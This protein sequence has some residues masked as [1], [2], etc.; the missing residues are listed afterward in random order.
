[1]YSFSE[2]LKESEKLAGEMNH[3]FVTVDHLMLVALKVPS[4]REMFDD[5]DIGSEYL[6]KNITG[7]LQTANIPS[8]TGGTGLVATTPMVAKIFEELKKSSIKEQLKLKDNTIEPYFIVYE[9]MSFMGTAFAACLDELDIQVRELSIQIQ[10]YIS[11][12]VI[13]LDPEKRSQIIN[14]GMEQRPKP[15]VEDFTDDL[16]AQ[17]AAKAFGKMIGRENELHGLTQILSRMKK[18][19]PLLVGEAGTGKTEIVNGLATL[20]VEGKVPDT[21]KDVT[22]LSLN[23]SA[24]TAGTKYRGDFEERV[25]T[26]LK[27]LDERPNVILFIDE[28]HM[29][30]GAGTSTT[31]SMDLGNMLKPA[32]SSGNIRII[33]STTLDEYRKTIEKD[34]ALSR[35]FMKIDINEPTVDETRK[36]VQGVKSMYE[37]YHNVKYSAGALKAVVDLSGKFLQTKKYPD[38]AI[39]LLDAAGA[40]NSV[41]ENPLDTITEQEIAREVAYSANLPVE[42]VTCTESSR[43]RDLESNI[44][45]RV[46]GQDSAVSQLTS[47]VMVARAGLREHASIQGAFLMVGSSG[48]GK[49]EVA[50]SLAESMGVELVRFDMSEFA[51]SHTVS[52]LLGAP[53]GYTGHD[54]GNGMLLDKIEQFPNCVLLLDEIEK[55]NPNVLLPLLQ[56]MDEGHLTG[57][58]GKIVHFNNVTL[59]MTT[60]LGTKNAN[61]RGIGLNSKNDDGITKAIKEFLPPEFINRIDSIIRFN[62]LSTEVLGE[63]LNKYMKELNDSLK[64]HKVKVQLDAKAKS[65]I[66][67][68]GTTPGMGA[69]PMKRCIATNIKEVLA[70]KLLFGELSEGVN[71]TVKFTVEDDK[72]VL[73]SIK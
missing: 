25:D 9:C 64:Q 29:M 17:A 44:R 47:N 61:S 71:K 57:S 65:W 20:I 15:K 2:F 38:K 40:R 28:I 8:S 37:K 14:M 11:Q 73:A 53:P 1:M 62:D 6:A 41:A 66:V 58:H 52:K 39:D 5:L 13:G 48:T 7:F 26:L 27:F 36:I 50:K 59:L 55:A 68:K 35:R 22:I 3:G 33:G 54:S 60:N 23:L 19:N 56:V 31:G 70:P 30:M 49:T 21:L 12:K 46:F 34:P 51:G 67:E 63:I 32:L 42:N 24:M 45:A 43:M 72:L 10:D 18:K 16:T 4:I 69:R